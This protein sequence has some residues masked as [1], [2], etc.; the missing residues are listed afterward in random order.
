MRT[1]PIEKYYSSLN[2]ILDLYDQEG[3]QFALKTTS[4]PEFKVWKR[5]VRRKL[6]E[7]T[8]INR[9][10]DCALQPT[11]LESTALATH[12]REKW[13]IQTE[14]KVWM[15]FYVLIPHSLDANKKVPAIIAPHGH[16]SAG[17]FATAGRTDIPAVKDTIEN[18]HYDYGVKFCEEGYVVFCPDARGF[19]ER[20]EFLNGT[21][22]TEDELDE[23]FFLG[24]SCAILNRKAMALGQSL[25][26][27]WTWD[28]MRL[29]DY[30]ETRHNC[31]SN[32]ICCAG[33]SGGGLQ[34]LWLAA[35]DDRVKCTVISGNY[36]GLKDSTLYL[37][38]CACSYVPRL[39]EYVDTGDMGALIAPRALLIESGT[40]DV[41]SGPR[42][43]ANGTEQVII[44]RDAYE[45]LG[46]KER[47]YHHVFEDRHRWD[48]AKTYAFVK[49]WL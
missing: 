15:P 28:L 2:H 8:G 21:I 9:M 44:T 26:G 30:I 20:R 45:L 16:H 10:M 18:Y 40:E 1:I 29:I 32:R 27:M 49:Q 38:R 6:R 24:D 31:E 42:G 14:P 17:K 34:T 39:S 37:T 3:R 35:L 11:L 41:M 48:G 13:I 47:L 7:I 23:E 4:I 12:R 36:F 5:K 22:T 33:L 25:A 46:V 43:L 19:G